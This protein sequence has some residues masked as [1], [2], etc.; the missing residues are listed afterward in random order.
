MGYSKIEL[1]NIC[2]SYKYEEKESYILKNISISFSVGKIYAI[3]GK[4][5]SGKTSLLN[6]IG[7]I[8]TS[9]KGIYRYNGESI[10]KRNINQ[11]RNKRISYSTQNP[12]LF[13]NLNISQNINLPLVLDNRKI[14]NRVLENKTLKYNMFFKLKEKIKNL[15][16]GQKQRIDFIRNIELS[17]KIIILDETLSGIDVENKNIIGSELQ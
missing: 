4:S 17:K 8:D 1:I 6:I 5:G 15:S 14:T 9:Y 7:C 3:V 16:Y 12:V 2:K 11:Y 13:S 10:N